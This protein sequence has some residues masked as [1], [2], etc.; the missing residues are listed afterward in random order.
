VARFARLDLNAVPEM[1]P[2]ATNQM[3]QQKKPERF[4]PPALLMCQCWRWLGRSRLSLCDGSDDQNYS[5]LRHWPLS[6]PALGRYRA[7]DD[8]HD[9][10]GR[11]EV[12]KRGAGGDC[13]AF[14]FLGMMFSLPCLRNRASP[15]SGDHRPAERRGEAANGKC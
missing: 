15:I 5:G 7:F 13:A 1:V 8:S 9:H 3:N 10:A 14:D 12:L 4:L 2:F 6:P 11:C